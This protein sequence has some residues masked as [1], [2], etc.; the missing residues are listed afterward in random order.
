MR[1]SDPYVHG[2]LRN[3]REDD[4]R[5][6]RRRAIIAV[7]VVLLAVAWRFQ[8]SG[9]DT[10]EEIDRTVV[11]TTASDSLHE[12]IAASLA[13]LEVVEPAPE[14][15]A[16]T[17][18]SEL[19]AS[20]SEG[21]AV[22]VRGKINPN[23]SLFAALQSRGLPHASIHVAVTAMGEYFDFR[24]SRPGDQWGAEVSPEG[25]ITKLRY[26]TSPEDIWETRREANDTFVTE[27]VQVPVQTR[28][29]VSGGLIDSSLWVSLEERGLSRAVITRFIDVFG[30]TVDFGS[31]TQP[32]DRFAI[33]YEQVY[34]NDEYLRPGR[35]LAALYESQSGVHQAYFWENEDGDTGYFNERGESLQGQFLKSPVPNAP[36]TS[37]YGPR[38]H[39]ILKRWKMHAG[40]DYGAPTG[41]PV[42]TISEGTV[43]F[44]GWK[45]P[46]GKTVI[47]KHA[48]GYETLYAHLSRIRKGIKPGKKVSKKYVV[49]YIGSTGRSTGPHLHFGMKHRGK[50]IDPLSV[51]FMRNPPLRGRTL[52]AYAEDVVDPLS[53]KLVEALEPHGGIELANV[54]KNVQ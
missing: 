6:T 4:R 50:T 54:V 19:T 35:V 17:P 44:A 28:T 36:I 40:V 29:I 7:V 3:Q 1:S 41:T 8:A 51:D 23:E 32:G 15:E 53:T 10:P 13:P 43:K 18:S 46:A 52:T 24:H 45:G 47:I 37:K 31:T 26:Q 49:G 14:P 16:E 38:M 30:H 27:K 42:M 21:E 33:I 20:W 5:R 12:S 25:K 48:N 2:L 34:L 39:P 9:D 22:K 11:V